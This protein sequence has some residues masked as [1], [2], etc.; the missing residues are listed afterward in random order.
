V[1]VWVFCQT[2]L[3]LLVHKR[4]PTKTAASS[5]TQAGIKFMQTNRLCWGRHGL[6][7]HDNSSR[8]LWYPPFAWVWY[9]PG[10][11]TGLPP[12]L[13]KLENKHTNTRHE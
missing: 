5:Y 8:E 3:E 7:G 1:P 13:L 11:H 4:D 9:S 2:R 10:T 6:R 12:S